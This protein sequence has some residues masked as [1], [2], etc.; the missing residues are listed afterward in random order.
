MIVLAVA[1]ALGIGVALGALGGGGSILAVPVLVYAAGQTPS[2][3]TATSLV[4]VGAAAAVGVIGHARLRRVRWGA[5]GAFVATGVAGSWLG[6]HLNGSVDPQ[7]LLLGFSVLM[8]VAAHRMLTA[9]P[10][11]T[12]VG[13]QLAVAAAAGAPGTPARR[14]L[15][16]AAIA[17]VVAAGSVVG[18]LTGLFGVGGGFIIV[19]ALTLALEMSLPVAIGTSLV[20]IVGNALVSLGFRG[21]GAVDW[22]VALPFTGAM[23]AG[24]LAGSNLG[25]RIPVE[26]SLRAFAVLLVAVALANGTAAVVALGT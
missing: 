1:L 23:L 11:C 20:V 22:A 7:V 12:N 16:G 10:S 18:L 9:C 21:L 19:P 8:V 6:S 5:A 25:H 17:R 2:S 15:D 3:A 14:G 13:E 4:A 26:R 24:S